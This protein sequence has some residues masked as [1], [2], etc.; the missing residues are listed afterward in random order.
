M[1]RAHLRIALAELDD[2]AG[3]DAKLLGIDDGTMLK[4]ALRHLDV[5]LVRARQRLK[6]PA[7]VLRASEACEGRRLTCIRAGR[8]AHVR[9]LAVVVAFPV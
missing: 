5:A 6:H 2:T 4:V 8:R 1:Q 7:A 9:K 3:H